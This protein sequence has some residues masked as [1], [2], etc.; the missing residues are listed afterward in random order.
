MVFAILIVLVIATPVY[1]IILNIFE[2]PGETM[3]HLA[4][5]VL[6]V[7]IFNSLAL[8]FGVGALSLVLGVST[9]WL[10]T[11]CQFPGRSV[12]EWALILPLAVPTYIIAFSYAGLVDYF[13]PIQSF[14]RNSL[15]INVGLMEIMNLRGVIFIMA[16]VLYPYVYVIARASFT[17]QS[18]TILESSRALGAG[19]I[20][21]FFRVALPVTR[22]AIVGGLFLVLMEV[23]NDYGAVKYY[24][25]STFTTGI[26]RAWFSI[27]DFNAAIY[28]SAILML[29]VMILIFGERW[30]RGNARYDEGTATN[31]PLRRYHLSGWQKAACFTVCLIPLLFGFL[32][33]LFQ[34][35]FWSYL[36][37]SKVVNWEF[38]QLVLNSFAL[39]LSASLVCIL[40]ATVLIYS[41]KLNQSYLMR[42]LAKVSTLGYSIPGAV[43][44]V[45]I[46]IPFLFIDKR[47]VSGL[48]QMT[49]GSYGLILS[50]T[51]FALIFAYLVRFL[52]VGYNPI[53]AGFK[54]VCSNLDEASRSLGVSPFPTLLKINIPL[55]KGTILSGALLVFVDVLKELPLT[56]ILRP[57]NFNTLATKAFELA[58]DERVAES[59][60][61]ALIIIATGIL[62][63]I[64]L[65]NL[66]SK[67]VEHDGITD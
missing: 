34:L 54:K 5:T 65:S 55:I 23:L 63:I 11:T 57:F 58:G 20:R 35:V 21:T 48:E 29:F 50:G 26:F 59:S 61:A 7:Y 32:L 56:L 52:A 18:R 28:L 3:Q 47:L 30:Q 2:G 1:T 46:M 31:R 13:G 38:L 45:G 37:A 39:A 9:A 24:G 62:P 60:N 10:I 4:G 22:P 19:A 14:F 25:V 15:S 40:V 42:G 67:R 53:D 51:T 43:I 66:I 27:G 17:H 16:F 44:A 33:P 12:F 36:T 8:I 49:G 6:S 64:L 41:V